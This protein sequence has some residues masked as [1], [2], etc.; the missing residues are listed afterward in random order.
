LI[1]VIDANAP[2]PKVLADMKAARVRMAQIYD[3]D[4]AI[5]YANK[6]VDPQVYAKLLEERKGN[7]SGV[8]AD[9]G[10]VAA[11][12][13][14]VMKLQA[15]TATE[16]PRVTR[17]GLMGATGALIGGAV[18]GYPGAIA[19]A[20]AGGA[21]GWIGT[22]AAAKKMTTSQYQK[23][24]AVPKDYRNALSSPENRNALTR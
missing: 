8:G 18:G 15:P 4:R 2:T 16:M 13:P 10:T 17:S 6:T 23:S 21:A 22:R 24:H 20:S 14:E 3:H 11:T 9:I 19:G 5:N 7:M 1:P 12:F